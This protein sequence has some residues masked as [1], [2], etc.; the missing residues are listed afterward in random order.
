MGNK[1]RIENNFPCLDYYIIHQGNIR[2]L[3]LERSDEL[4]V[5]AKF[6]VPVNYPS[7]YVD[8]ATGNI[9]GSKT[10]ELVWL[11]IRDTDL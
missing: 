7:L 11:E 5:H 8:Q 1:S 9:Y 10:H 4:G 3:G 6:E 2:E